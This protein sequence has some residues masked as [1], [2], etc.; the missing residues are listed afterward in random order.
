MPPGA[1]ETAITMSHSDDGTD[2]YDH[3]LHR[4]VRARL[5]SAALYDADQEQRA[6]DL[7]EAFHLSHEK[8]DSLPPDVPLLI[9]S[10]ELDARITQHLEPAIKADITARVTGCSFVVLDLRQLDYIDSS[11]IGLLVWMR[12]SFTPAC[13][14]TLLLERGSQIERLVRRCGLQH[15]FP[16]TLT[17]DEAVLK[18]SNEFPLNTGK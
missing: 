3:R 9:A 17:M 6:A 10:G 2:Y 12:K 18:I 7:R 5:D 1:A 15:L 11:G 4:N 13:R 14:F 16:V 8:H